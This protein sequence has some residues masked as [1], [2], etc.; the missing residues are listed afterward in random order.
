MPKRH[1][2][3]WPYIPTQPEWKQLPWD[4][5]RA[6]DSRVS[7]FIGHNDDYFVFQIRGDTTELEIAKESN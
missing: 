7:G 1:L 6:M 4:A 3:L 5:A 2:Q